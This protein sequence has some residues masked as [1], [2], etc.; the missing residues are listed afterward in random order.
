MNSVVLKVCLHSSVTVQ[1]AN[2]APGISVSSTNICSKHD[3]QSQWTKVPTAEF[4]YKIYHHMSTMK[5]LQVK[6]SS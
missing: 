6:K 1:H 5:A 3:S 2:K 4:L